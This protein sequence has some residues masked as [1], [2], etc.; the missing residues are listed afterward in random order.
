M[1]KNTIRVE[2]GT[3]MKLTAAAAATVWLL[4]AGQQETLHA[5]LAAG[6]ELFLGPYFNTVEF[7]AVSELP[8]TVANQAEDFDAPVGIFD[9]I[10]PRNVTRPV[11]SGTTE[12]GEDLSVTNGVWL[13][14]ATIT[15]AYQWNR[16]G[17]A[18]TDAD[19]ATYELVEDDE[20]ADIT[21]TVTATNSL[22]STSALSNEVGP[23]TAP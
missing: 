19:E 17:V 1:N 11:V 8:V 9:Y 2:R 15:F 6:E 3:I 18:I 5:S 12:T 4:K 10:P 23:I 22:G 21:C 20:D 7:S 16:D 13:G 14:N